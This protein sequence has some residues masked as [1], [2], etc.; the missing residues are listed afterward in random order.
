MRIAHGPPSAIS[1]K[2]SIPNFE[3]PFIEKSE[4]RWDRDY[5]RVRALLR[6]VGLNHGVGLKRVHK[7]AAW[8][9]PKGEE[10]LWTAKPMPVGFANAEVSDQLLA[11]VCVQR[12]EWP[13][14]HRR[15]RNIRIPGRLK[16]ALEKLP[17]TPDRA[18][19]SARREH[20]PVQSRTNLKAQRW[21][22]RGNNRV[23]TSR[24][25]EKM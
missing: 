11:R 15:R 3:E 25:V 1:R 9:T 16:G 23:S 19:T 17:L 10:K 13:P 14:S 7:A 4:A 2:A 6:M 20:P 21:G 12:H 5:R 24:D 18:N 8:K 22:I